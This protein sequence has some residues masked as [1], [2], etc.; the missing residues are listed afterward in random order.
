MTNWVNI[1]GIEVLIGYYVLIS[2]LGTMPDLPTNATYFQKWA[3]GAAH[4]I[5]GNMKNVAA[6]LGMKPA[7]QPKDG[8]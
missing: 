6:A 2:I 8:E 3:Y 4:A 5:C 1:H 7:A